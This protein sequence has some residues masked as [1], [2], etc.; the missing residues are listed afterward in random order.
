MFPTEHFS[1]LRTAEQPFVLE[2]PL[3]QG[4][5]GVELSA[6]FC[7]WF[8]EGGPGGNQEEH[9]VAFPRCIERSEA[10][11]R[12][13]LQGRVAPQV[14]TETGAVERHPVHNGSP[15]GD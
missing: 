9:L 10:R 3:A 4:D 7:G 8:V 13:S 15:V 11:T 5:F 6:Q 14:A 2:Q 12:C 1:R